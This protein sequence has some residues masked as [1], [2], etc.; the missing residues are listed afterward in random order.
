VSKGP[1]GTAEWAIRPAGPA[2]GDFIIDMALEAFNW[3][4]VV[5]LSRP[6]LLGDR[7]LAMYG[8]EWPRDGDL[9]VVA[10]QGGGGIGAAWVRRFE[11]RD[12]SYGFV[13][14]RTPEL[15]I[16]VLRPFRGKG[17]GRSLLRALFDACRA[18][19]VRRI[20]L[21]VEHGNPAAALYLSEGFRIVSTKN[22]ADTMVEDLPANP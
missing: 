14:R 21:S 9:G 11:K 22:R 20:S 17:V 18:A 2:D 6:E 12:R 3:A 7:Q 19:G 8:T 4:S 16:A 13:D 1:A 5:G 15:T 10:V